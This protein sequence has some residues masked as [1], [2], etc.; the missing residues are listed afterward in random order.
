MRPLPPRAHAATRAARLPGSH[1]TGLPRLSAPRVAM[2]ALGRG[3]GAAARPLLCCCTLA[4]CCGLLLGRRAAAAGAAAARAPYRDEG[5]VV[6]VRGGPRGVPQATQHA[7]SAWLARGP[8]EVRQRAPPRSPPAFRRRARR[9]VLRRATVRAAM[10]NRLATLA[11]GP[12]S[13]TL[14]WQ[15]SPASGR[16]ALRWALLAD[17]A[18]RL[19]PRR[20]SSRWRRG[21]PRRCHTRI[22]GWR[23]RGRG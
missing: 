4:A 10:G 7:R 14:L 8:R 18:R 11:R 19:R 3:A 9:V 15:G 17:S 1:G 12:P 6:K 16:E 22:C 2:A 5:A 21:C 20:R 13:Q 23:A